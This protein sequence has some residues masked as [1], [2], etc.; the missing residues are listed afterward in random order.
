ME[1][2]NTIRMTSSAG[3]GVVALFVLAGII[4]TAHGRAASGA[5]APV[6]RPVR[7]AAS[8]RHPCAPLLSA[9]GFGLFLLFAGG[10][11]NL[12][13]VPQARAV[14]YQPSAWPAR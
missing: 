7:G 11:R 3:L 2:R 9:L 12:L 10:L 8:L 4:L 5:P 14:P 13:D 6:V 1:G